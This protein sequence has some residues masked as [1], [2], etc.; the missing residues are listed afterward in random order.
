MDQWGSDRFHRRHTAALVAQMKNAPVEFGIIANSRPVEFYSFTE[1]KTAI[2][3]EDIND[4]N[5][6]VWRRQS[7]YLHLPCCIFLL[8]RLPRF[9]LL[10]SNHSNRIAD[11]ICR[12]TM[13][14]SGISDKEQDSSLHCIR[15]AINLILKN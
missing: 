3:F 13:S 7:M 15:K 5:T 10:L 6:I 4:F 2:L 12:A 14:G 11:G 9:L 8:S 1:R